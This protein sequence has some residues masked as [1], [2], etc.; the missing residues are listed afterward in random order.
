MGEDAMTT[1]HTDDSLE[2]LLIADAGRKLDDD[3]FSRRVMAALPPAR[4]RPFLQPILV[5]GS[6]AL[7][8]AMA[9]FI[10]PVGPAIVQGFADLAGGRPLT[11][12]ALTALVAAL[13]IAATAWVL[14]SDADA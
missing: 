1:T 9:T 4:R 5:L 8:C 2:R 10:A 11:P 14:A 3:G 12:A 7:G 13:A 6:T